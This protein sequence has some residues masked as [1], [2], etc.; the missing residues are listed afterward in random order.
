MNFSGYIAL[1]EM[2]GYYK[3]WVSSD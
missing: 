1:N 3:W 2:Q